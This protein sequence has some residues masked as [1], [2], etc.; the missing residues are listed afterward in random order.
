MFCVNDVLLTEEQ[1]N[2]MIAT[3]SGHNI[4]LT[5][6]AGTEKSFLE[7]KV[8]KKLSLAGKKCS[9]YMLNW[10]CHKICTTATWKTS[11]MD[12]KCMFPPMFSGGGL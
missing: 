2:T 7:K 1:S 8:F 4:L 9:N 5:G 10:N 6:Q 12:S 11:T 3:K